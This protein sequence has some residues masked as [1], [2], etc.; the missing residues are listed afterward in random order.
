MTLSTFPESLEGLKVYFIGAKGT[1]MAALAEILA[2]RGA[3]L[4]GSDVPDSFYT[5][6][7]LAAIGLEPYQSF[8]ASHIAED[9]DIVL[10]SDA[11]N[12]SN[13]PEMARSASLG[14]PMFSF[15]QALGALSRLSDSSG[16]AGVHGKTTTTAMTG[17]L[18]ARL[19]CPATV[20]AG[21]AVASF[22]GSCTMRAGSRYFVAETDEYRRHFL[23]FSPR[24]ILL[25][26]IESDHQ[27]YYPDYQSIFEA[28]GE[29]LDSLPAGGLLLY[30]A[31]D[32]GAVAAASRLKKL[33]SDLRF[34]P[35]GTKAEGPWRI[36][37]IGQEEGR[38]LFRISTFKE[39][40]ELHL[41]GAHLVLDAVAALALAED[42]FRD[43]KGEAPG[44]EEWWSMKQ[45]L[46]AFAGSKRRSEI[47]GSA[48]G[49]LFMDDYAHHPTALA[50]TIQGIKAFWP[51]RRLVVDFMSHTYSRT[52]ALLD[53]FAASLDGA[54]CLL[55]HGIYSSA[56]ERPIPGING[57]SLYEK[58]RIRRPE[59][60]GG[61]AKATG[62]LYYSEK[63]LDAI[64]DLPRLLRP[65]D[66]FITMGAGDNWKLGAAALK[67]MKEGDFSDV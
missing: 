5:D 11:Y 42:I 17:T 58:V 38:S 21:S 23:H 46:A 27:D 47:I 14:L 30:C 22:G 26:S 59:L 24:R 16:V 28:Y 43:W 62:F 39:T 45:A 49:V 51:S 66:L 6:A 41:P 44:R 61:R 55:L 10:Y 48:G 15:A 20:L 53:D 9:I 32:P 67:K 65:G 40:L 3:R 8:D 52:A 19:G 56:R 1:G 36:E 57:L 29:Y 13:N 64:E 37:S 12:V 7:V 18:L 60:S 63:P 4:A 31:D 2:S 54:D 34:A 50:A 33:R 35:Y 25:T